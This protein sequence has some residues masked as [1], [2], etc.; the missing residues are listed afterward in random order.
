L[1]STPVSKEVIVSR[2]YVSSALLALLLVTLFAGPASADDKKSIKALQE[3][4]QKVQQSQMAVQQ[5]KNQLTAEKTEAEQKAAA[6]KG[7]LERMRG[8]VRHDLDASRDENKKLKLR[9][10]ELEQQLGESRQQLRQAEE[11]GRQKQLSGQRELDQRTQALAQCGQKNQAL[12]ALNADLLAHYEKAVGSGGWLSGRSLTQLD[13]VR[14]ENESSACR[15]RLDEYK[16]ASP[17]VPSN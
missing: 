17:V 14:A 15:D 12:L 9:L 2:K 1:I 13:R 10:A 4:L 6:A 8:I 16:V 5:E 7:E 11:T 3:R